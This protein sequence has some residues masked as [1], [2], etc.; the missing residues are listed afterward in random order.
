MSLLHAR[1]SI[2]W[3]YLAIAFGIVWILP[4]FPSLS[5]E[6]HPV[7]VAY[8]TPFDDWREIL[9]AHVIASFMLAGVAAVV[10]KIVL[11]LAARFGN[12]HTG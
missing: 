3:F 10:H 1:V 5:G 7:N 2:F 4:W 6:L 12:S 8:G 11:W 9:L